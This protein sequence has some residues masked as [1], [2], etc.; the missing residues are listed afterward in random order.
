M[1]FYSFSEHPVTL[2]SPATSLF[3][4]PS[5]CPERYGVHTVFCQRK[6]WSLAY[7]TITSATADI[8]QSC[9]NQRDFDVLVLVGTIFFIVTCMVLCF[10]FVDKKNTSKQTKKALKC[11]S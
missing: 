8:I 4:S 9:L 1:A 6:K 2:Q 10:L 7:S 3:I 5:V 11:F